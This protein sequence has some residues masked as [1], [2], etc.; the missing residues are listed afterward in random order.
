MEKGTVCESAHRV[1]LDISVLRTAKCVSEWGVG[2]EEL[3]KAMRTPEV[4]SKT[5]KKL[6][7]E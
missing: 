1:Y 2:S 3:L 4:V 5:R 6:G 7:H